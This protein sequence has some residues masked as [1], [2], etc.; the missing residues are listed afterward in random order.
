M[1]VSDCSQ[2]RPPSCCR[3]EGKPQFP[4][5][6]PPE[7]EGPGKSLALAGACVFLQTGAV[8]YFSPPRTAGGPKGS[9]KSVKVKKESIFKV[10][11]NADPS[12]RCGS[13]G[14][15]FCLSGLLLSQVIKIV[16]DVGLDSAAAV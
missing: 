14:M 4:V 11:G 10:T 6:P 15:G 2:E 12:A 9:C 13:G 16:Y 7:D 5:R 1:T 8:S 3:P